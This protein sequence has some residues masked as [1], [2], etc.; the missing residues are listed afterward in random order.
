[1]WNVLV[2]P[3]LKVSIESDLTQGDQGPYPKLWF[4]YQ[5]IYNCLGWSSQAIQKNFNK[6]WS[7][8]Q[9]DRCVK[10]WYIDEE[11]TLVFTYHHFGLWLDD[12]IW[13]LAPT[14]LKCVHVVIRESLP[15]D[16]FE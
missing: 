9:K 13:K 4:A 16:V 5:Q 10:R 3:T 1:M 7:E 15:T 11:A 14:I 6:L 8:L 2:P 12:V